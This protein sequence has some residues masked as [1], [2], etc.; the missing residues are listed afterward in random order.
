MPHLSPRQ[1][2]LKPIVTEKSQFDS[3]RCRAYHFVVHPKAN[4][5]Q[6]RTAIEK[7]FTVKVEDVRTQIRPGKRRRLGFTAGSKPPWKRAIVTLR[8]GDMIEIV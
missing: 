5:I 1:V 4:K 3:E 7:I 6:I 2:V 8:E